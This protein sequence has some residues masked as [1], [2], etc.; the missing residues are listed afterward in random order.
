MET[1]EQVM[2]QAD[3]KP[4]RTRRARRVSSPAAVF[5]PYIVRRPS[6]DGGC[7]VVF[8]L[9]KLDQLLDEALELALSQMARREATRLAEARQQKAAPA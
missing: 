8:P 6:A 3:A 4:K 7:Q 9:T 5:K 1:K 2:S